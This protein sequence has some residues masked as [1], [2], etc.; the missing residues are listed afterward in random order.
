MHD[1]LPPY[2][3]V[4]S[5][6]TGRVPCTPQK[7]MITLSSRMRSTSPMKVFSFRGLVM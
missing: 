2:L 5:P 6:G 4:F 3:T 7:D 1:V